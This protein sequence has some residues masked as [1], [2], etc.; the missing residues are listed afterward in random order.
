M[1]HWQSVVA[2]VFGTVVAVLV[3]ALVWTILA[4]GLYQL[5][6]EAVRRARP[7]PRRLVQKRPA[8]QAG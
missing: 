8:R 1:A 4:A 7:A 6:R 2:T 3:P 5:I